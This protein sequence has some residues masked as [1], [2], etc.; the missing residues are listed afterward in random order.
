MLTDRNIHVLYVDFVDAFGSV[1]HA[2]LH[3]I[4]QAMGIPRDAV[5][6]VED[7]YR[8]AS[9]TIRTPNKGDTP[10]IPVMGRGTVQ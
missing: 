6:L 3:C 10:P 2:R 1:D 7:L 4:M 9:I 8:G 5:R